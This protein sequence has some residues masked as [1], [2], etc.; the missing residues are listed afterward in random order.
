LLESNL[1]VGT[2]EH[3][4]LIHTLSTAKLIVSITHL[5]VKLKPSSK[6]EKLRNELLVFDEKG[7]KLFR[8]L[9]D[10]KR[11]EC[12]ELRRNPALNNL[13]EELKGFYSDLVGDGLLKLDFGLFEE[14]G[15]RKLYQIKQAQEAVDHQFN[16]VQSDNLSESVTAMAAI[17]KMNYENLIVLC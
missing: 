5:L 17:Y 4:D 13:I 9:V 10:G 16:K 15:V 1:E 11:Q 7:T 12:R 8:T 2:A 3:E 14:E 6:L